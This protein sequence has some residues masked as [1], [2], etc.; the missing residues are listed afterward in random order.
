MQFQSGLL[1]FLLKGYLEKE[2]NRFFDISKFS[3]CHYFERQ[4]IIDFTASLGD[5]CLSFECINSNW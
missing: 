4:S 1:V 2:K 3:F 5:N